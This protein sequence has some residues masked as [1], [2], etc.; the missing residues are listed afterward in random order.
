MV[1]NR[2]VSDTQGISPWAVLLLKILIISVNY[3]FSVIM[4]LS[5]L[6]DSE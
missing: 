3:W 6:H 5:L 1:D 2:S 4:D